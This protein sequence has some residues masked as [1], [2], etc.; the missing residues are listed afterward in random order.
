MAE[1][2]LS[3]KIG[4]GILKKGRTEQTPFVHGAFQTFTQVAFIS[5][6][7]RAKL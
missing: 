4:K 6:A 7:G 2:D 5:T 3:V 1:R